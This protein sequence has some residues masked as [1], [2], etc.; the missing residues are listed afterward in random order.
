MGGSRRWSFGFTLVIGLVATMLVSG[1]RAAGL[2]LTA[3][4][5]KPP[6]KAKPKPKPPVK[7]ARPGFVFTAGGAAAPSRLQDAI[8][9]TGTT[10]ALTHPESIRAVTYYVDD[11]QG[12][13]SS[14]KAYAVDRSSPFALPRSGTVGKRPYA[15][16]VHTLRG[17]IELVSG[18]HLGLKASY[19][20]ARVMSMSQDT[21]GVTL[22]ASISSMPAGPVLVRPAAPGSSFTVSG[23]I[24][25]TRQDVAI[26][27]A[28]IMDVIEFSPARPARGCSTRAPS[29]STSGAPTTS[30]SKATHSTARD[31]CGRTRCGTT[32][33]GTRP[34]DS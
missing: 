5:A 29:A 18:R 9:E 17:D 15:V 31:G 16:G 32:R 33:L 23:G 22:A 30:S 8:I 13:A 4:P 25:L 24:K 21:D 10:V 34:M 19:W 14:A 1:S 3:T 7:L 12:A 6:V 20:V 11:Q 26:E 28:T 27:G 2:Q